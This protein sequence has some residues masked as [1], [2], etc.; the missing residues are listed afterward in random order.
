MTATGSAMQQIRSLSRALAQ[1]L[2]TCQN[3]HDSQTQM[4]CRQP[5]QVLSNSKG[6]TEAHTVSGIAEMKC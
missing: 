6:A 2:L 5:H 4:Q 3:H 1:C